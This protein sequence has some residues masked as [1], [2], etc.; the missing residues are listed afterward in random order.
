MPPVPAV[1][2]PPRKPQIQRSSREDQARGAPAPQPRAKIPSEKIGW[3]AS[4]ATA[5]YATF[6]EFLPAIPKTI[7]GTVL[8][9]AAAIGA[10]KAWIGKK[11][12]QRGSSDDR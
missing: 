10:Y 12:E 5:G 4:A 9:T 3:W 2:S 7:A 8:A 6:Q 1:H 11:K